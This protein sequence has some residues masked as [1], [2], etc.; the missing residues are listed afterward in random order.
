MD[1]FGLKK[2]QVI[3]QDEWN[4]LYHIGFYDNL[5]DSLQDVNEFLETY[6]VKVDSLQEYASTF[7][8]C[9]DVDIETPTEEIIMVRGF[10][11]G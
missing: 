7:G 9:F 10:I 5:D 6:D 4:N 3:I 8:S 11:F 1:G 2:Y